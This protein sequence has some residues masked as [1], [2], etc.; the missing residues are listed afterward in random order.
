MSV[1]LRV[2]A[3]AFAVALALAPVVAVLN[4]W[5]ASERWPND[6]AQPRRAPA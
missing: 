5:L 4:G 6:I 1:L 2:L 3:W